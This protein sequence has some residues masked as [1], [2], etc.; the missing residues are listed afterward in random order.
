MATLAGVETA[1]KLHIRRGDDLDARDG[2]GATPLMLAAGRKR[3]GV[4]ALLLDAGANPTLLDPEGRHALAYAEKAGCQ[5]CTALLRHAM[6]A[7]CAIAASPVASEIS[8]GRDGSI[9]PLGGVSPSPREAKV[10]GTV[11]I[12]GEQPP[13]ERTIS[14]WDAPTSPAESNP[15]S[16]SPEALRSAATER[17]KDRLVLDEEAADDYDFGGVLG[18]GGLDDWEAE[19]EQIAPPGDET[20]AANASVIHKAIGKHETIDTDEDWDDVD[21]FLPDLA[22][23]LGRGDGETGGIRALL[24]RG[25]K[26]GSVPEAALIEACRTSD[27][28][29]NE[30]AERLLTFVLAE[31][32]AVVDERD[33]SGEPSFHGEPTAEEERDLSEALQ[34]AEDLS[35]DRFNPMRLYVRGFRGDLLEAEEEICLAQQIE[36]AGSAALDALAHWPA[37]LASVVD[38]ADRVARGEADAETF[39]FGPEPS[40]DVEP[41]QHH[42][43]DEESD[44]PVAEVDSCA[45]SFLSAISNLEAEGSDSPGHVRAALRAACLSRGFLLDLAEKAGSDPAAKAFASAIRRQSAARERMILSNLRLAYSVAKKYRWSGEQFDDL[46]QDANLGLMKAVDRYDWRKGFRF[47]TYATWWIRQQITRGIADKGRIVRIPV[48]V[49]EKARRVLRQREQIQAM[50]GRQET[51]QETAQRMAISLSKARQLLEVLEDPVSLDELPG[52]SMEP[53]VEALAGADLDD[54]AF[55]IEAASLRIALRKMV[56]EL[57]K[58]SAEVIALRFGLWNE[59]EMTL[60][61]VGRQFD[62]TRERIRQI[63]SKALEKLARPIRRDVVAIYMGDRFASNAAAA[64]GRAVQREEKPDSAGKRKSS[65][66]RGSSKDSTPTPTPSAS[67]ISQGVPSAPERLAMLGSQAQCHSVRRSDAVAGLVGQARELGLLVE[68]SRAEGGSVVVT[69]PTVLDPDTRRLVRKLA[70]AGVSLLIGTTYVK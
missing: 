41:E 65:V 67:G 53:A 15:P 58:R 62:V 63:E 31:L 47:S 33:E 20:L 7:F 17:S 3:K 35:A 5:E 51:L 23:P 46:V 14:T 56:A 49:Q 50:T 60:E 43:E 66:K 13:T 8:N 19:Q 16:F 24:Y 52:A 48:H 39:S 4:L 21:A 32:G 70:A 54:P 9:Q 26:E 40:E 10:D 29:R 64:G 27:R 55:V 44:D 30:E 1:V 37:G 25:L 34:Y 36:E 12:G 59:D 38:A 2:R 68:D 57:D 69:L 22:R 18:D 61:E 6:N 11:E 45:T 28:S 42:G